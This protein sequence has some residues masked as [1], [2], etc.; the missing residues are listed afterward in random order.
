MRAVTSLLILLLAAP[1]TAQV[2]NWPSEKPPRPLREH[3]V[4]FPP[5][6]VTTLANGLQV[7]AVSHHEQPAVSL[8]L[9]VRAGSAQDPDD[10]PGVAALAATLLDQGTAKRSAE[11][12][13]DSIDSIGGALG[14]GAGADLSYINTVVMKDSFNFALDLVSDLAQHPAFA[15]EEIERQRQQALSGMRVSYDDPEFL[16]N[17]VFDRLVYGFHPY[18][19]PQAGTPETLAAVTRDDLL[20]FHRKWFGANNAILAVGGGG[21][22]GLAASTVALGQLPNARSAPANASSGETSPTTARIA[23]LAP[24]HFL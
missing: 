9:I 13:A 3:D 4:R 14:T 22:T 15:A 2:R 17:V 12:I 24:N 20:A 21:S 8:R 23:L 16:A 10:K 1:A 18:G 6:A 5:F 19:R 11:Q 7:I